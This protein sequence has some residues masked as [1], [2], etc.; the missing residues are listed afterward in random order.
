MVASWSHE[1]G[2]HHSQHQFWISSRNVGTSFSCSSNTQKKYSM[3]S[4]IGLEGV[5]GVLG[6][7]SSN[8]DMLV[9]LLHGV[10]LY[11]ITSSYVV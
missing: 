6:V 7:F 5:L 10:L 11:L 8:F 4:L 2:I 3:R 1:E 9:S